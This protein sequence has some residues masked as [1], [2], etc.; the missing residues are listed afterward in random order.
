MPEFLGP[1]KPAIRR[2]QSTPPHGGRRP[3]NAYNSPDALMLVSIHAPARGATGSLC[4]LS[5]AAPVSIH[6][7]ARGAT[8]HVA[9]QQR[10]HIVSIHA[11]ARGATSSRILQ[12]GCVRS[13]AFQSTPPHGGRPPVARVLQ[14]RQSGGFNPRPRT[15]GDPFRTTWPRTGRN[16]V[17]IHA[18]ARGA[19]YADGEGTVLDQ[20]G[21]SIHAPA[22]GATF[23]RP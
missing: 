22:R 13:S 20:W 12:C 11:P 14:G 6:A 5:N 19:T 15:G 4:P 7:P 8:F 10:I 18:P 17:S 3:R 21:V 2:F 1:F 9:A 23:K 16:E